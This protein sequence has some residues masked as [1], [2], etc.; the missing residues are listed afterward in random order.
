VL[1]PI[2]RSQTPAAQISTGTVQV[3]HEYTGRGPTKAKTAINED[4]VTVLMADALTHAERRLV[5]NGYTDTV[6]RTRAQF[7]QAMRADLVALV[8][9]KLERDV[10]A[11]MSANH[12][13]PDLAIE[14]FVLAPS[15]TA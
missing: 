10:V 4:T 11:F 8:E 9:Q 6:L 13:D 2:H 7:Q 3:L 15:E 14:V 12:L 1:E 5:E